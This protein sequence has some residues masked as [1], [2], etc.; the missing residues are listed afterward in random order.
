MEFHLQSFD[1]RGYYI[2]SNLYFDLWRYLVFEW[3]YEACHIFDVAIL[4]YVCLPRMT[5]LRRNRL[6]PTPSP[7]IH[8]GLTTES[9]EI[10]GESGY[11]FNSRLRMSDPNNLPTRTTPHWSVY[12]REIFKGGIK[13]GGGKLLDLSTGLHPF[14]LSVTF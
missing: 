13:S 14:P 6:A 5:H 8:L 12:P 2:N 4:M 11:S 3:I 7:A 9:T 1:K 10:G